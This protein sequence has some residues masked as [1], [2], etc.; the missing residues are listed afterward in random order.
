MSG[1][2]KL[3]DGGF[4]APT[5]PRLAVCFSVQCANPAAVFQPAFHDRNPAGRSLQAVASR[6][7]H[8]HATNLQRSAVPPAQPDINGPR[9]HIYTP[10]TGGAI[11]AQ[12]SGLCAFDPETEASEPLPWPADKPIVNRSDTA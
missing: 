12:E 9:L 3:E 6:A 5:V 10:A 1:V 7:A 4:S 8:P 2:L 11:L